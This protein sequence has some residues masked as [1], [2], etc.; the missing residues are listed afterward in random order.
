MVGEGSRGES[1]CKD[2]GLPRTC[3]VGWPLGLGVGT[4]NRSDELKLGHL[5][6]G[7]QFWARNYEAH[8][9]LLWGQISSGQKLTS[10]R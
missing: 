6:R 2:Q 9:V 8:A 4:C 3:C 5:G 1:G 10:A 7:A